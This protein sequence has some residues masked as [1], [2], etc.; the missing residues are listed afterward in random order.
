MA[1]QR[2]RKKK[3]VK[4]RTDWRVISGVIV[5]GLVL[6]GGLMVWTLQGAEPVEAITLAAYCQDNPENC[7]SQGRADAAVTIVEVSDYG[8]SYCRKFHKETWPALTQ[9]Y[10]ETGQAQWIALPFALD[11]SRI[12]ATN[13]SLCANDQDAYFEMGELL[14]D[15]QESPL[16]FTRDGF[17]TA[18]AALDLD[19]EAFAA[20]VDDG[21]Y[22]E[23]I[24]RNMRVAQGLDVN[25]TPTFFINGREMN[26]AQPLAAFQQQIEAALNSN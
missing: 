2:I 14:Y 4:R 1:K 24:R 17:M 5:F 9:Q 15:Q 11:G 26:G 13:A 20:C 19:M 12:P 23:I 16:A 8:C 6:L 22:N 21:R 25:S 3:V 18:A 10:I 7:V